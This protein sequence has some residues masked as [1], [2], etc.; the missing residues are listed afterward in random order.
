M[1]GVAPACRACYIPLMKKA[2]AFLAIAVSLTI[3]GRMTGELAYALMSFVPY[4]LALG[5]ALKK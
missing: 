4:M 3:A 1:R 2:L 5:F